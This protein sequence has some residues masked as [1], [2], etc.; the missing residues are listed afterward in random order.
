MRG[1]DVRAVTL[2]G[3]CAA[4]LVC[5][6]AACS[7]GGDASAA[8]P[9]N[10]VAASGA[11]NVIVTWSANRETAVNQPGGGYRLYH[12]ASRDFALADAAGVIDIPY[13]SGALAP[14]AATITLSPGTHY[15]RVVAYSTLNPSGSAP[16][17]AVAV[18]V[19]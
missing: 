7:N 8:M 18:V 2:R 13:A 6:L 17:A 15:L 12:S 1:R 4:A 11:G 9:D 16:S 19:P 3:A 14:T 10:S 5:L